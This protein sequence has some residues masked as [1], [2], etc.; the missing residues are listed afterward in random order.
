MKQAAPAAK[1]G[2]RAK[3][4]MGE[5]GGIAAFQQIQHGGISRRNN[6][7]HPLRNNARL[8]AGRRQKPLDAI[9]NH[10]FQQRA[11]AA[12][13]GADAAYHIRR[14]LRLRV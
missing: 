6:R 14:R 12:H 5:R 13:R 4:R 10:L 11:A 9:R 2:I 1:Q 7:I 3:R 8:P